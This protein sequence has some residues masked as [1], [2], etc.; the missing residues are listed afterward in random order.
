M[1]VPGK[2][3]ARALQYADMALSLPAAAVAGYG[4]GYLLD[5]W[6][7]TTWL[8]VVL[9][10]VGIVGAFTRMVLQILKDQKSK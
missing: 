8:R 4:L 2:S 9:L 7:G 5:S 10:L 6:L 1:P 3:I